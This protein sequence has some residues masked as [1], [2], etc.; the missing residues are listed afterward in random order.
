MRTGRSIVVA[1]SAAVAATTIVALA[2]TTVVG[3]QGPSSSA[4]PYLV[5]VATGVRTVS[6]LTVGDSV[7]PKLDGVTPYKMVGIPDGLGAFDNGDGTFQLT[8]NHE[9]AG[10]GV[11]RV[12][13]S[14][15]AFVSTWRIDKTTLKVLSGNDLIRTIETWN[16]ATQAYVQG[17]TQFSRFCSADMPAVSA[18]Y[19][20]A[21]G[22]GTTERIH[23]NGE[24]NGAGGRAFAHVATGPNT[25][26][27]WELPRLGK[28]SWENSLACP[29][30][31]TKTIVMEDDDSTPGQ[32]FC[33]VGTKLAV[34]NEVE[35][36]GLTNGTLYG[37]V[38]NSA[39]TEDRTTGIGLAKGVAGAFSLAALP[40]QSAAGANTETAAN[41]ALVTKFNRPEDGA[42]DPANPSDYYFVTTD[43][44][45]PS[46]RSRLWKLHFSDIA[47]PTAGGTVTMLLDGTEG[48]D[49][50][51]N[52]A[53]D[54][55]G[56]VLLQE[57]LGTNPK[58]G[59]IWQYDIAGKTLKIIAKH[60]PAR[61]GDFDGVTTT[62]AT[63]PFNT[64][65]ESSGIIDASDL[66]GPGWFLCDVQAHYAISGELAEGGQL[67]ALYNP[68]S[69]AAPTIGAVTVCPAFASV[70]TSFS[71]E[72]SIIGDA[73]LVYSWNFGDGTTG[74]GKSVSHEFP[75]PGTYTVVLTVTH[76]ASGKSAQKSVSV[77]VRGFGQSKKN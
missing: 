13:G 36:A 71:V 35:K 20:A 57:D 15:R 44:A 2:E 65:E 26:V 7:N 21:T 70:D 59:K 76:T 58:S 19:D 62:A 56:H 12:H 25:G 18:F 43:G 27:S 45:L 11:V 42:W 8:M 38:A 5:P 69:V 51:D 22:L 52:I 61:F 54:R 32:V 73:Q 50:Y 49:M 46:G 17:T 68:D 24:E 41:T 53:I 60:D 6:I 30:A 23:M 55:L 72:A 1:A 14:D 40:D 9:L 74:A 29:F 66:L 34:G 75:K 67:L 64:D 77:D 31:Q 37:V 28:Q 4:T 63:A 16:S 3:A 39:L 10:G 47:T 33:Y 48:G